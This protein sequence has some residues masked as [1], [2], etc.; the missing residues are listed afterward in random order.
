MILCRR[1]IGPLCHR[2][3][4]HI[5]VEII[6]KRMFTR[7]VAR[8]A[9]IGVDVHHDRSWRRA[10]PSQDRVAIAL[11]HAAEADWFV[12]IFGRHYCQIVR[13]SR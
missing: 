9:L 6:L 3:R 13:A 7:R 2:S 10:I 12:A 5:R 8:N 11:L 1:R 4:L